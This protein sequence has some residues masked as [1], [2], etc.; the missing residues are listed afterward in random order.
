MNEKSMFYLKEKVILIFKSSM[1]LVFLY[2]ITRVIKK[3][4]KSL[5]NFII[6]IWAYCF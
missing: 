4:R 5:Q 2:Q 6:N 1:R 3:L